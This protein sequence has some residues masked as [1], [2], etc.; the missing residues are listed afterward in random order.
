MK[1]VFDVR[2]EKLN[3]VSREN[4]S[5]WKYIDELASLKGQV[6]TIKNEFID[7]QNKLTEQLS[8]QEQKLA[9]RN[10][11]LSESIQSKLNSEIKES[12]DTVSNFITELNTVKQNLV[13]KVDNYDREHTER[14]TQ[15]YNSINAI[16]KRIDRI[17]FDVQELDDCYKIQYI[18]ADGRV[19]FTKVK[20]TLADENLLTNEDGVIKFKYKLSPRNFEIK[21]DVIRCTSLMLNT[22]RILDAD[23]INN[24]LN[25]ATFNIEQLTEKVEQI[26]RK[27]NTLNG[28][29]ASNNFKRADPSQVQLSN[30]AIECLPSTI[31]DLSLNSIPTGTKIKNTFDNHIWI[32]NRITL[33]GL[34]IAKWEDFGSDNICVA[35]NDGVHGL[36]TGSSDKFKGHI[37][38]TGVISI[39]GLEEELTSILE[40]LLNLSTTMS[41]TQ[42]EYDKKLLELESRIR[43]LEEN[44]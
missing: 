1:T 27:V 10:Q 39:N 40:S 28:Y 9:K 25:N 17:F 35:S 26:L 18:S 24:N 8:F 38:L 13:N 21:N 43:W 20:K 11:S 14:D 22:G 2:D 36:V 41:N 12:K 19:D 3:D 6:T 23:V 4:Q 5:S 44:K 15:I 30:F 7:L 34:T 42:I 31:E 32:L 29:V 16:N 33:D 37:D